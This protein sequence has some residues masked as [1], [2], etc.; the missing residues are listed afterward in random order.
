MVALTRPIPPVPDSYAEYCRL[1]VECG[2]DGDYAM[3]RQ[4][5]EGCDAEAQ[6]NMLEQY[7]APLRVKDRYV[8]A[9]GE[10]W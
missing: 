7:R 10:V 6:E 2:Y 1:R 8:E 9:H 3:V 5:W 4:V